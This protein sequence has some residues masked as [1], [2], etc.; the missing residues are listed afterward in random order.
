MSGWLKDRPGPTV[1]M[2]RLAAQLAWEG[3][4]PCVQ[5][6]KLWY[7]D[8]SDIPSDQMGKLA[9]IG[10]DEVIINNITPATLLDIILENV[11]CSVLQLYYLSLTEPQTRALV[12]AM[13]D[14]VEWVALWDGVTL[15]I[16]ALCQYNGRG[17][18]R[19][20]EVEGDTRRRY[21][22]RLRRWTEEVGWAV[23]R[24]DGAWLI[25]ER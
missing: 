24:N 5:V 2:M 18:C 1:S 14:G 10:T 11:R 15:D 20:L 7:M 9:S 23:T 16:E 21:G 6:M 25:M 22:E 17:T 13:R 3:H 8:L 4:L 19:A 12:T